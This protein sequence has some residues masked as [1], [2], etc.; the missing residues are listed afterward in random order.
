[1]NRPDGVHG[2]VGPEG[3]LDAGETRAGEGPGQVGRVRCS[4][5]ADDRDQ[6]AGGDPLEDGHSGDAGRAQRHPGSPVGIGEVG[7]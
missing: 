1:M 3:D 5:D 4:I 2:G 7:Q 6:T